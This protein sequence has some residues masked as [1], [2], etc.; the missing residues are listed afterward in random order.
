MVF[1]KDSLDVYKA[2]YLVLFTFCIPVICK[3]FISVKYFKIIA[4]PLML[5]FCT[6][7]L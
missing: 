7:R 2:L 3:A 5:V 1:F 4:F 6:P